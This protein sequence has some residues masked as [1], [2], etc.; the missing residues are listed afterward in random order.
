MWCKP[1]LNRILNDYDFFHVALIL[2]ALIRSLQICV[3]IKCNTFNR[4]QMM[5]PWK[6]AHQAII[7][8]SLTTKRSM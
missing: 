6:P 1:P 7:S 5:F 4:Q 2:T 8:A 3:Q